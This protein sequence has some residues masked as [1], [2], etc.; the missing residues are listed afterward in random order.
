MTAWNTLVPEAGATGDP[1]DVVAA[2]ESLQESMEAKQAL[3]LAEERLRTQEATMDRVVTAL[4]GTGDS[5][6]ELQSQVDQA[7][8]LEGD[9][10]AR[11]SQIRVLSGDLNDIRNRLASLEIQSAADEKRMK[12]DIE[13]LEADKEKLQGQLKKTKDELAAYLPKKADGKAADGALWGGVSRM[14]WWI[15]GGVL[16][17]IALVAGVWL[18]GGRSSGEENE[19]QSASELDVEGRR[20]K[21]ESPK[22]SPPE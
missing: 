10:A 6:S 7:A 21:V 22:P 14:W 13:D 3:S 4:R 11:D 18:V 9:V 15:G 5:F 16:A 17:A 19:A 1:D 8:R 2:I 12:Q 20:S